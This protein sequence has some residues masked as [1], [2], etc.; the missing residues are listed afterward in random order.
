[1]RYEVTESVFKARIAKL[2]EFFWDLGRKLEEC[3]KLWDGLEQG[4]EE[5]MVSTIII[6]IYICNNES[7]KY[8]YI[9]L[10]IY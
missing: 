10:D 8:L 4:E 2:I 1:M 5:T 7:V 9:R 6:Y 3:R